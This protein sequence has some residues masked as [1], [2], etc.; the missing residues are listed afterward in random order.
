M[1]RVKKDGK[2]GLINFNGAKI[3][4]TK[5]DA[6]YSLKGTKNSLIIEEAGNVGLASNV[7]DI[8]VKTQYKEIKAAGKDYSDGYIVTNTENKQGLISTDKKIILEPIYDE[9]E[10]VSG[11]GMHVVKQDGILK[12]INEANETILDSN[13]DE[14]IQINADSLV[15][16]RGDKAGALTVTKEEKIP[17]EYQELKAITGNYFIAKKDGKYGVIDGAN[18]EILEFKYDYIKQRKDTDFIEAD[19]DVTT[20]IYDRDM[21]LRLTG[22]VSS[23][24]KEK[25]FVAAPVSPCGACRQVMLEVEERYKIPMRILLYGTSGTYVISS[26]KDLMPLCFVDSDMHQ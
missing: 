2:Y 22:I 11:N 1:L 4:D 15:L 3:L 20:E 26:T 23:D 6:I 12:I 17:F 25:G 8:I 16:K 7:G 14:V 21:N 9:I 19:K 13:F 24:K 5:Y 18:N 10:P